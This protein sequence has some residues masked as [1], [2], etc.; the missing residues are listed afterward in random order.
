M[1][2]RS[3]SALNRLDAFLFGQRPPGDL[4]ERARD[5][6]AQAQRSAEM[7]V[8]L[9]Q[10]G[11]VVFFG[12]VYALTPKAFP[13]DAPFEPVPILLGIYALFTALRL[14]LTLTG[15]LSRP[16]QF[17]S[18]ALD[19]GVLT[20]TIWSF[21]LQ[22]GV[23]PSVY[24]KAPTLLYVFILIAL[25]ALRMEADQVIFAGFCAILG[26]AALTAYA[27][28]AAGMDMITSDWAKYMTSDAI[29]IG[30]E[31]D[32]LLTIAAVTGVLA[33]AVTRARRM[34]LVAAAERHASEELSRFF[35]R[36]VASAIRAANDA[37]AGLGQRRE[38]AVLV[39]DLRGFSALAAT[40]APKDTL[41]LISDYQSLIVPII[42]R[43][44]GSVD[45]YLGDGI[46]ATF[47]AVEPREGFARD[48]FAALR[49]ILIEGAA[50]EER[51]RYDGE[52]APR[53][54]AALDVGRLTLG[55][56]GADGRLEYTIIG[57]AV[58]RASKLEKHARVLRTRGLASQRALEAAFGDEP[59]E[60]FRA[61]IRRSE[62]VPG[63]S[64]PIDVAIMTPVA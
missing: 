50:W 43:H 55:V 36:Q 33:I 31:V 57:H 38:A 8:T 4:P 52:P 32:K 25:R 40:M 14:Y 24:L 56:V 23:A 22:Y 2:D 20:A 5:G 64:A 54:V 26:Y 3:P 19:I 12:A 58:N 34:L 28:D 37:G 10:V 35:P 18:I 21:H 62:N 16:V 49:E 44:G 29:L 13:L 7:L 48:A 51:R 53:V 39:V 59:A 15:R 9:T 61:E 6:V 1:T 47:G 45:K 17:L 60:G 42:H 63:L 30:A 27:L 46:L 41:A 11:A